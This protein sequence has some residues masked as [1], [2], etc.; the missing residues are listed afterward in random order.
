M[1]YDTQ[2]LVRFLLSGG[3]SPFISFRLLIYRLEIK[4]NLSK[5]GRV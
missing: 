4:S 5:R 1:K 3:I 2:Y